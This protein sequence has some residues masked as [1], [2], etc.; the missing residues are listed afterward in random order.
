MG[1]ANIDILLDEIVTLPSAPTVLVKVTQM[2]DDPSASFTGLGEA[3]SADPSISMKVLRLVNSAYYGVRQ[4]VGSLEH[5]ISL[6]GLKVVK[7]LVLT[8]TVFRVFSSARPGQ[9]PLFDREQFWLHCV[10]TGI[11]AR[12]LARHAAPAVAVD[13]EEAFAAGLLHDVGKIILDQH[14]HKQFDQALEESAASGTPLH[15]CENEVIGVNHAQIGGKLAERWKLP[16]EL[17]RAI[18]HHHPSRDEE[19]VPYAAAVVNLADYI[20][21]AKEIGR[22][23]PEGSAKLASE[24]WDQTGF[25]KTDIP[26][27]MNEIGDGRK[28]AAELLSAAH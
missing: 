3:I 19:A 11:V 24:A 10:G 26:T 20:C 12:V 5:A 4:R 15:Q 21:Y 25:K 2:I 6:L 17:V 7:N 27:I 9:A 18:S 22:G 23:G 1:K 16:G 13:P 28:S 8:A 14:L